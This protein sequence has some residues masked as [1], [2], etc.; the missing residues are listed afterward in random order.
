MNYKK[1]GAFLKKEREQK[2]LSYYQVFETTRIQPSIIRSIEEGQPQIS[3]VFFKN[4][5]KNYVKFLGLDLQSV[6]K[7]N[8]KKKSLKKEEEPVE[9]KK[10]NSSKLR[11]FKLC[12]A[13]TLS[14]AVFF[15]IFSRFFF[16]S[17]ADS[18]ESSTTSP[19]TWGK[20]LFEDLPAGSSSLEAGKESRRESLE[21]FEDK[22]VEDKL[23]QSK[24][25]VLEEKTES[26]QG[27]S[28][29]SNQ[30]RSQSLFR[31]IRELNFQHEIMIKSLE[32]LKIYFKIDRRSTLTKELSPSIWFVI[33]AKQSLYLRFDE[34]VNQVE[35][36]YNGVKWNFT[37]SRFFEKTFKTQP[38]KP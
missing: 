15:I 5:I 18:N 30:L 25:A 23:A 7:E 34:K 12:L 37:S 8:N 10:K 22:K 3:E 36:F 28:L 11:F 32:P 21:P 26:K 33:K 16:A 19:A 14:F 29:V 27:E 6:L 17:P 20:N 31:K 35:M 2:G 4:F 24:I 38:V 1:I 9:A 13:T